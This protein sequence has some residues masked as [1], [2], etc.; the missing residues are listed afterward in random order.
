[1]RISRARLVLGTTAVLGLA[2][3]VGVG[4]PTVGAVVDGAPG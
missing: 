1:M 3:I 2:G 4:V